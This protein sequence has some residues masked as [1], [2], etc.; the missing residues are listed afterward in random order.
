MTSSNPERILAHKKPQCHRR[1]H[2]RLPMH[3]YLKLEAYM[4][5]NH[6]TRSVACILAVERYSHLSDR[7]IPPATVA[8]N[9][10][11][12]SFVLRL[13]L[14]LQQKMDTWCLSANRPLIR[15]IGCAIEATL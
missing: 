1:I 6:C 7:P 14:E 12:V 2:M 3:T 11:Y 8:R 10:E 9:L 13:P 5:A 4:T 15:M